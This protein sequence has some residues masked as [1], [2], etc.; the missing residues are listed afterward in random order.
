MPQVGLGI[1]AM[2]LLPALV[3]V[4]ALCS[5]SETAF[6]SLTHADRLRLRKSHPGV[7]AIVQR[8]MA[9]PRSL[10]VAILLLN[11]TVNTAYFTLAGIVGKGL[12]E[13][14]PAA[15]V[16][17]SLGCVMV[18]ILFGEVLPKALAAVHRLPVCRIMAVP[19]WGWYRLIAPIRVVLDGV[20]VGPLSRLFRPAGKGEARSLTAEDLSNLL[21][22]GQSE[23]VLRESEQQLLADVVELG[24]LRVRDVMTPRVD[25][26]WLNA[27]DT[28]Q[29]L[30][31]IARETGFTRYPVCRGAFN[32]RQIVGIVNVQHVFP[33]LKK[34]GA[35][36]R[37]PL[38]GLVEAV[39]FVPERARVDQLLEHFRS[40]QSD[41]A[42]VVSEHGDVAGMVQVDDVI[43]ELVKFAEASQEA[44]ESSVRRIDQNT[45]EVPGRL[46][47]RD[48]EEFFEP[49]GRERHASVSTVA[50]LILARLGRV[51]KAGEQVLI[52]NMVMR[53]EA[54]KG[55][56]IERVSVRLAESAI[57]GAS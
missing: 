7:Y 23:G 49:V 47:V 42:V 46:S 33:Q 32:E 5:G 31:A 27:T 13:R 12:F 39:R 56:T 35:G 3:L 37:L 57:G 44:G 8:L 43:G 1:V 17:F 50:G 25:V 14:S 20:I 38:A 9:Q 15:A 2:V 29:E 30:L 18:L 40:T 54:M 53:V 45:W 34:S 16:G 36:A 10:L 51:P 55:R 52:S 21:E 19:V 4:S 22:L 11:V 28:S 26:A 41:V 24:T 48:W 6:F